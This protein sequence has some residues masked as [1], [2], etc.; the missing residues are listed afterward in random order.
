VALLVVIG[1]VSDST[2]VRAAAVIVSGGAV[3]AKVTVLVGLGVATLSCSFWVAAFASTVSSSD[4]VRATP[5]VVV[6][7]DAVPFLVGLDV[8]SF[9]FWVAVVVI[10]VSSVTVV[11]DTAGSVGVGEVTISVGL[12]VFGAAAISFSF[13]VHVVRAMP[14][15]GV[16]VCAATADKVTCLVGLATT[17]DDDDEDD[18]D[19]DDEVAFLVGLVGDNCFSFSWTVLATGNNDKVEVM[20]ED[21]SPTVVGVV[22]CCRSLLAISASCLGSVVVAGGVVVVDDD[23]ALLLLGRK[24]GCSPAVVLLG[25]VCG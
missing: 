1:T 14:S 6:G 15:V 22:F 21:C 19:D 23:G 5:A 12:V 4:I 13:W 9:S 2:I 25:L 7:G 16:V 8:T 24:E 18:D 20:E 11:G 10:T 3:A 17:V